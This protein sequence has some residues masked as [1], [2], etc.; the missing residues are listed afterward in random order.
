MTGLFVVNSESKL[1]SLS[2][3]GCSELGCSFI[4]STKLKGEVRDG[5]HVVIDYR[6]DGLTFT[7]RQGPPQEEAVGAAR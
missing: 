1:L 4:R 2:P 3:C 6:G 5:Q 7:P